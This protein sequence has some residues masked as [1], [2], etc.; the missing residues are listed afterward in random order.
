MLTALVLSYNIYMLYREREREREGERER[1]RERIFSSL[2]H[3]LISSLLLFPA[4]QFL[5]CC[6]LNNGPHDWELNAYFNCTDDARVFTRCSVPFSCCTNVRC[7][8]VGLLSFLAPC[9]SERLNVERMVVSKTSSAPPWSESADLIIYLHETVPVTTACSSH[10]P[11]THETESVPY[12]R[13]VL[14]ALKD[15][16]FC[17]WIAVCKKI[18]AVYIYITCAIKISMCKRLS[19]LCYGL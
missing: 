19:K 1:E 4:S 18:I 14:H 5:E 8:V 12:L 7:A 16:E 13:Y 2:S 11:Q 3:S 10:E 17:E 15:C 9:N 6:G